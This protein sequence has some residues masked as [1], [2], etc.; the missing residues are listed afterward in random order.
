MNSSRTLRGMARVLRTPNVLRLL[1]LGGEEAMIT[2]RLWE[3]RALLAA[4]RC[5]LTGAAWHDNARRC[6]DLRIRAVADMRSR[7]IA[8][9][10]FSERSR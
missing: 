10:F 4:E 3:E 1:R 6:K 5:G 8:N 7:G 9:V 2:V